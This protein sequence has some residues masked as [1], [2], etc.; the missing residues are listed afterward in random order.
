M[1]ERGKEGEKKDTVDWVVV[2]TISTS[3]V[4]VFMRF[5]EESSVHESIYMK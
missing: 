3:K 2:G 1:I 4:R 5:L